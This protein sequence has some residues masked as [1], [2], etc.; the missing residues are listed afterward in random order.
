MP[1]GRCVKAPGFTLVVLLT[2]ALGIGANTAIFSVVDAVLLRPLPYPA[3][4]RIVELRVA[5]VRAVAAPA[6]VTPL[7]FQHWHDHARAFDAFAVTTDTSFMMIRDGA[8]ERVAAVAGTA[9]F[10]K[11]IGVSPAMGRGFLPGDCVPG[12]EPVAVISH[13]MWRRVFGGARRRGGE[14]DRPE[15]PSLHGDWRDARGL[16]L[17]AGRGGLV[18]A[19]TPRRRARSGS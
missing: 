16:Q 15:R 1:S 19:A 4:D 17:R 13:G 2:L 5:S 6:N 10:F 8:A 3:A 14:D 9:D 7:T 12:A 18:A 11:A